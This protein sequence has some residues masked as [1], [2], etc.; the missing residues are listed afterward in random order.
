M[1][2]KKLQLSFALALGLTLAAVLL[3]G[4]GRQSE[5][6][7]PAQPISNLQSPISNPPSLRLGSG[8]ATGGPDGFGYVYTDSLADAGLYNW[9]D[10][11]ASGTAINFVNTDTGYED[12]N[13]PSSFTFYGESHT[14]VYVTTNG[15]ATFRYI[16]ASDI[17]TQC[18]PADRQPPDTLAAFCTDLDVGNTVYYSTTSVYNGH[19][20]FIVQYDN[21]T[22]TVSGL[23]ATFQIILDFT[24]D[25]ITYQYLSAPTSSTM[26][27][28]IGI[29]GYATNR[30]DYMTYCRGTEDC[31]P[32]SEMA[33]RF[34]LPSRPVL[35]LTIT[36]SDDFPEWGDTVTYTIVM[37]NTGGAAANG[38]VM[39]NALPTGLDCM[40]STLQASGGTPTYLDAG[41]TVRWDG[42]LAVSGTVTVTYAAALNTGD[43][44][45]NTAVVTHPRALED[46]GATS[47]PADEWSDP[48]PLAAPREF[49]EELGGWR[50]IAVDSND[51]PHVAYAGAGLYYATL[52]GTVWLSETVPG[53]VA[54]LELAALVLDDQDHARIAFY[55][56]DH[57][58]LARQVS[59]TGELTWT[60]EEIADITS[61]WQLGLLDLQ[62]GSDGSLHL[63][64][65]YDYALYYT[66]YSDTVWLTPTLVIADG[67]CDLD[68]GYSLA[69]DQNDVP[70]VACTYDDSSPR[71]VRLYTYTAAAPWTAYAVVSSGTD[72]YRYPSLAY[73]GSTPHLS[74]F[75]GNTALYH[76]QP[77]GSW[78]TTLVED[79]GAPYLR[80]ST[81][82]DINGGRV[83]IAYTLRKG[84]SGN[85]TTIVRYASL[86]LTGTAW[87]T[88]TVETFGYD[89]D[90]PRPA[91]ALDGGGKAHVA[92]YYRPDQ[93]L[94]YAAE[95]ASFTIQTLDE[96][97]TLGTAAVAVGSDES[98]HVAYLAKGLYYATVAS[99]TVTWTTQLAVPGV[100]ADRLDLAL[101]AADT[102]NVAY[103]DDRQPL[104]HATLSDTTWITHLVDTPGDVSV[105]PSIGAE[106][107]GTAHI[108]YAAREGDNF[109]V[110]HAGFDSAS[111]T[112]ETLA[113]VGPDDLWDQ[114]PRLVAQGGQVYV[115]YADCTAYQANG[116]YP[117][118]LVLETWNGSSWSNEIL[119]HF[120]GQCNW[121]LDYQLLAGDEAGQLTAVAT[122]GGESVRPSPQVKTF[123]IEESGGQRSVKIHEREG[124]LRLPASPVAGMAP[125]VPTMSSEVPWYVRLAEGWLRI[126]IEVGKQ[127]VQSL[128]K[129]GNLSKTTPVGFRESVVIED[130]DGNG[131]SVVV[132]ERGYKKNELTVPRTQRKQP[133]I[134]TLTLGGGSPLQQ[135][136]ADEWSEQE[137]VILD[138]TLT[139]DGVDD[140]DVQSVKFQSSGEGNEKNDLQE[141]ALYLGAQ[142]L[143][144]G[145]YTQDNGA[146]TLAVGKLILA[147]DT[148]HLTLKYTFE[149]MECGLYDSLGFPEPH[150]YQV[151]TKVADVVAEPMNYTVFVTKPPPPVSGALAAV[152]VFNQDTYESFPAIQP[153]IDDP[154]T[155]DEHMLLVC[156]GTYTETVDVSK[157]LAILSMEGRDKTIVQAEEDY[158]VFHVMKDHTTIVGFTI[159]GV[160][161]PSGRTVA[162]QDDY[163]GPS[164][165]YIEGDHSAVGDSIIENNNWVGVLIKNASY[166]HIYGNLIHDNYN[167][168]V[169]IEGNASGNIIGGSEA[170]ERNVISNNA[171]EA[172]VYLYYVNG[173]DNQI[174]GN[175]IG[176]DATGAAAATRNSTGIHIF[177][178]PNTIVG[179]A[180][181]GTRNIISGNDLGLFIVGDADGVKIQG[182]FIGTDV[183]GK[184]AVPNTG[185]GAVVIDANGTVLIGGVNQGEGNLISGNSGAGIRSEGSTI[186]GNF[187]G[188]DVTGAAKLGNSIGIYGGGIIGGTDPGARNII[189][190]ND[191][192]GIGLEVGGSDTDIVNNFIGV[193]VSGTEALGN[194]SNGIWVVGT[195]SAPVYSIHI[196]GADPNARNVISANGENGIAFQGENIQ[197]CWIKGNYI[198]LSASGQGQLGNGKHGILSESGGVTIGGEEAN[199]G[200]VVSGNS[201]DGI[202]I[203]YDGADVLGNYIGTNYRGSVAVGNGGNGVTMDIDD[204]AVG[205]DIR[206]NLISGN[207][208]DGIV[209]QSSG[210]QNVW[211]GT[212]WGSYIQGN[213]IGVD[214][215]GSS[216][217]GNGG[218][219]LVVAGS[220]NVIGGANVAD[221]NTISG[222]DGDGLVIQGGGNA[223]FGNKIGTDV[224][225]A[226][227]LGNG[228]N[229][230]RITGAGSD[231][232]IGGTAAGAGNT[233]SGNGQNGI[234][235]KGDI[236]GDIMFVRTNRIEGNNIGLDIAGFGHNLGNTL[237]GIYISESSDNTISSNRIWYNCRG[238]RER[239]ASNT[240]H[241][242]DI[243]HNTCNTGIHLDD[244]GGDIAGNTISN[245]AHGAIH[246]ENGADP[247]IYKNNITAN[248]GDGI[249][250]ESGAIPTIHH[251]NV[252]T[253]TGYGL[254]NN[255]FTVTIQ[256]QENWWGDAGG[257]GGQGPG[258][259]DEV[260]GTVDFDDWLTEAVAVVVVAG[261]DVISVPVGQ[262]D[263]NGVFL[264][265]LQIP[266]DTLTVVVTDTLGWLVGPSTFTVT[267]EGELGASAVVSVSVPAD[268]LYGTVDEVRVTATSQGDP[269]ATDWDTFQVEAVAPCTALDEVIIA[270]PTTATVGIPA[271]FTATVTPP[272]ATL[273]ITYTWRVSESASQ[274]VVTHTGGLSDTAVFT[275]NVVGPQVVTVTAVNECGF[276]V[277]MTCTITVEAAPPPPCHELSGV[278]LADP[279]TT[280]TV[281][282]PATFTATVTP[283]TATLSITYT[284][285]VSE[286]ASQRVVTH[287]GGLS[288]T[289]VFTWN[290]VGPQVVTV[291]AVNECGFAVS[292]T[293]TIT[294]E[295]APPPPCHE[296]SG[297]ELADPPTTTTVGI[298]A[299]FTATVTPP[300]ATLSITYTWRV[301]ES[302]S[303][304]V[305]THTGGLS[306]TAVFTWNVTGT[307]MI[308]VTAV[309]E[310][311]GGVS[312]TH[313][314]TVTVEAQRWYIYLPLVVRD[315]AP[316]VSGYVVAHDTITVEAALPQRQRIYL[317]PL[318]LRDLAS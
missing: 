61:S 264:Q 263:A 295:A 154:D 202:H 84:S 163:V 257:P 68:D 168:G 296:L 176:T 316:G 236:E 201:E 141:V 46:A 112:T 293:C 268:T 198:G 90:D 237:D 231:N 33:V 317:P 288:D 26:T 258:S 96:S 71:Q 89:W 160:Y 39:T 32:Q 14:K 60:V 214:A 191:K 259:G 144:Y 128:D 181:E 97:R 122:I 132:V 218:N 277:S 22:H 164:G 235:I 172:N 36:P 269:G 5:A 45:Y 31:P 83:G 123:W 190:G 178:A 238:I 212:E 251:N 252:T 148:I 66:A 230:I 228:R 25:S 313:T 161:K 289:A 7:S 86:P 116:N 210:G 234:W 101:D 260:S 193:D 209:L 109:V 142:R 242:N 12:L 127:V 20:T 276:A 240:I 24:D 2:T 16:H 186:Q 266:S 249:I 113:I 245:D 130:A 6:A 194:G 65:Y 18:L 267:L 145:Q 278:E 41:R 104:Y 3:L 118:D 77:G 136:C 124:D 253:N 273:S 309:N 221:H 248:Q 147:G 53:T 301:S 299:T 286:S 298:P 229:G 254:R 134:P 297:V 58:W 312:M 239:K 188:T 171:R 85:Y 314:I 156:P 17:V 182:N 233:I 152:C 111:W 150:D 302:A 88:E 74:F 173:S 28:T 157:S 55:G 217:L 282:I 165:V 226:S 21:V 151:S 140:W 76:A 75:R 8:Q 247:E 143:S 114:K 287:T 285:R 146:I 78:D 37:N 196:G 49:D 30:E 27:T 57:L 82:L 138:F 63:V 108:A 174:L 197:S 306:D 159:R 207:N 105:Y 280:T 103:A 303:Q 59:T 246:C 219:G 64:Y 98:I 87:T 80:Q 304:R 10:I 232:I 227:K 99:D 47:S 137:V 56:D 205:R 223:V 93:G 167:S 107:T 300:T 72:F 307:Q 162:H 185:Y 220:F 19:E 13:L 192:T 95:T 243:R 291:T 206:N 166:G 23:T 38:A 94:R 225:G 121:N 274:R 315:L 265:N 275:W 131:K 215:Q 81:A 284:W 208:H 79:V 204:T 119:Y 184:I 203:Y 177:F 44:I 67:A 125:A 100:E 255:T 199:A 42:D 180:T 29:I 153:A 183:T 222:N 15:Y 169:Q 272:T 91:L 318:V 149:E 189:S 70:H 73:D 270:G 50:H 106:M 244:A 129:N 1:N 262:E 135:D 92:Y 69:L 34:S 170:H 200:N 250:A 213:L 40:T 179:G 271:T 281:G 283:P 290:V 155:E 139:A 4:A 308:T 11:A 158:H 310:C 62:Q 110:R 35:D 52:S 54:S 211:G 175:F 224:A 115:M 43:Y 126:F 216:K 9:V 294:V 48:E 279:P 261:Q 241:G 305:V 120:T 256:A 292:M 133:S 102:P 195:P 51:V 311:G 117:I 187:I